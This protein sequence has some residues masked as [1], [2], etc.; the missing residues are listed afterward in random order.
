MPPS[1]LP[2]TLITSPVS[3]RSANC[4]AVEAF[5][6]VLIK[7]F[8]YSKS[9]ISISP[10]LKRACAKPFSTPL[11]VKVL[12]DKVIKPLLVEPATKP[13]SPL[14]LTS[15][16]I[17]STKSELKISIPSS[18]EF[19]ISLPIIDV[20]SLNAI[21]T[22]LSVL[23]VNMLSSIETF[24]ASW[25]S[26]AS[27]P[28]AVITLSLIDTSALPRTSIPSSP[29]S[30]MVLDATSAF[31]LLEA[32]RIPL[33]SLKLML[34]LVISTFSE[35]K[36]STPSSADT[37]ISL[38]LTTAPSL[39]ATRTALSPLCMNVFSS[40]ITPA[41]SCAS[42][43]S[44]PDCEMLLP[45]IA[46]SVL[47]RISIPSFSVSEI[48]LSAITPSLLPSP[49][50]IPFCDAWATALPTTVAPSEN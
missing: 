14:V 11:S 23:S 49:K 47:L 32:I 12:P 24:V 2:T 8:G 44:S 25:A 36:M 10:L 21:R 28:D 45:R 16:L 38:A 18:P 29:V 40:M 26:T 35:P 1:V 34:L 13:F 15:F 46:I 9:L 3:L 7:V 4:I 22:P 19:E 27:S 39:N 48:L 50:R 41:A 20:P 37:E 43:E 31:V 42:T 17:T 5:S 6:V 30:L 33:L